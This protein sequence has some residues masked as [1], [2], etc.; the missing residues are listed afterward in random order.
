MEEENIDYYHKY[1]KY[2]LK[3]HNIIN[4]E[5][6]YDNSSDYLK[7]IKFVDERGVDITTIIKN[8]LLSALLKFFNGDSWQTL[9]KH[10]SIEVNKLKEVAKLK[11]CDADEK[12]R[13]WI[14]CVDD[15]QSLVRKYVDTE[16]LSTAYVLRTLAASVI[17]VDESS[18]PLILLIPASAK[19]VLTGMWNNDYKYIKLIQY[20]TEKKYTPYK[21]GRLIMGFGPS[22]SGKTFWAKTIIKIFK[23]ADKTFPDSFISIDGGIYR[24]T[25]NVY[26]I[27]KELIKKKC[28]AGFSNLF[29]TNITLL[30]KTLFSASIIKKAI[31]DYLKSQRQIK[32][33]LYVPETLGGCGIIG[34]DCKKVYKKFIEIT[35]DNKWIGLL[36]WQ[37]KIGSECTF[38]QKHKCVGCTESGKI[39]ER[40]EGKKYSNMAWSRSINNGMKSILEAP[41]GSYKI[42]NTGGKKYI[43]NG[44]EFN[45]INIIE[46]LTIYTKQTEQITKSI[47]NLKTKYNYEYI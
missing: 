39:R 42:H 22:A 3:Y 46:D 18:L 35:R 6:G 47:E 9:E 24:E 36:I 13:K 27:T 26:Q 30:N 37:H 45:C 33:N 25:S 20:G 15:C 5:G 8:L 16:V 34:K 40:D 7:N 29:V 31:A 41:G 1:L 38:N 17:S 32:I 4:Q 28:F 12:K 43:E 2:K 19:I 14:K 11:Q 23:E 44:K 21:N 10:I